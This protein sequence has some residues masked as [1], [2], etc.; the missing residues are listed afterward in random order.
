MRGYRWQ[1][2][3]LAGL[4]L[5]SAGGEASAFTASFRWCSGSPAFTLNAV[6]K[7][8]QTLKFNMVDQQAPSY[9]HGGGTVKYTGQ[10]SVA[11]GELSSFVGPS[12]PPPQVHTYEFTIQ[13]V[14]SDG[15]V[16]GTAKARR[17]FPE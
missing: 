1:G 17:K 7:G 11:C 16:L 9:R 2:L 10:R 4:I 15:S 14:G 6:P 5:A 8:T 12:P 13:A 3:V